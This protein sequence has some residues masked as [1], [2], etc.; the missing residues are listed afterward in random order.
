MDRPLSENLE[1]IRDDDDW[2]LL[3]TRRCSALFIVMAEL[4]RGVG[5]PDTGEMYIGWSKGF[6]AL[7]LMSAERIGRGWE[8]RN[9]PQVNEREIRRTADRMLE[10]VRFVG[11]LA[12]DPVL[13]S[14]LRTCRDL[15]DELQL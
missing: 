3:A 7:A 6:E 8:P 10:R 12:N 4:R 2:L 5:D 11:G 13:A 15:V 9:V 1:Q 14:D